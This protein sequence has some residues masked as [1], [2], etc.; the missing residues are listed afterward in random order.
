MSEL[1]ETE[2]PKHV[3]DHRSLVAEKKRAAMRARLLDAAMRVFSDDAYSSPVIDDVIREAAVSRGTFYNYF[4]SLDEVLAAIGRAF[5]DEMATGVLPIYDVLAEP[6]Q[7]ASVGFRVFL[8]RALVDRKW[9]GFLVRVDAWPHNSM[10]GRYMTADLESGRRKGQ[11][12]FD[13]VGVAADFL[14]GASVRTIQSIRQGVRDPDAYMDAAVRMELASLGC[15]A[16]L[17]ARGVAF[18]SAYLHD[19]AKGVVVAPKPA[20]ARHL[21]SKGGKFSLAEAPSVDMA[22]VSL[23]PI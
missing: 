18:S 15:G 7:R 19:W 4:D 17:A 8:V 5:S 20:W 14:M 23:K 12:A 16:E 9:A 10:V 11:F 2:H 22:D 21:R 6:W 13:D 3:A 1:H